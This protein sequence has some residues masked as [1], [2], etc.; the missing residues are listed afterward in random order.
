MAKLSAREKAAKE[1]G[2]AVDYT[3]SASEQGKS[4]STTSSVSVSPRKKGES[5]REFQARSTGGTLNYNTGEITPGA[6]KSAPATPSKVGS[7]EDAKSFINANQMT[8]AASGSEVSVRS[9]TARYQD[10]ANQLGLGDKMDMSGSAPEAPKYEDTYLSLRGDYGVDTLETKLNDLT[11][12]EEALAEQAR[13]NKGAQQGKAVAMGVIEGRV[14]E[15]QQQDQDQMDFIGRQKNTIQNELNTK[16]AVIDKIIQLK[17]M[18]YDTAKTQYDTKFSQAVQTFN[19][20]KGIDDTMKDDAE[21]AQDNARAN[22]Q[23]IYNNIA[24]NPEGANSLTGSTKS[25]VSKLELQ[26]GLPMG[27]YASIYSKNAGGEILSTTTRTDGSNNKYVDVLVKGADGKM[28]VQSTLLGSE[29]SSNSSDDKADTYAANENYIYN[30]LSGAAKGKDGFINPSVWK[31][32]L[33][34][35]QDAGGKT[36]DFYATY[37]GKVDDKGKRISGFIN[38]KDM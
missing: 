17:G 12:Q 36:T 13:V 16:Y 4:K 10:I 22:L 32:A 34:E 25:M 2:V 24:N 7:L 23:I 27:T 1:A 11:A 3:K 29:K 15:Q 37:G 20:V 33:K 6:S 14:S 26:A 8:D 31:S 21:R 35:W 19:I 28:K 38:P 5:A 9:S 18:D 30:K